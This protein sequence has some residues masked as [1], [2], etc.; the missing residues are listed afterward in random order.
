M[1]IERDKMNNNC[2]DRGEWLE[3]K[4]IIVENIGGAMKLFDN[5]KNISTQTLFSVKLDIKSRVLDE[6]KYMF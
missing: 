3:A 4:D 6:R 2:N 5:G 1:Q